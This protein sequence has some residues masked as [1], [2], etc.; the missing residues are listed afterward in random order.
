MI[1]INALENHA[2]EPLSGRLTSAIT[3]LTPADHRTLLKKQ[4][5]LRK[6]T[7]KIPDDILE[8]GITIPAN[9]TLVFAQEEA[10]TAVCVSPSGVILTCSHCVAETE[11]DLSWDKVHW[12]LFASGEAVAA[13]TV[14][15]DP[16]RDLALMV[17]VSASNPSAS[18]PHVNLAAKAPRS[19]TRFLCV[20]HPASE[21]LETSIPGIQTNYDTLVLSEGN[22]RGLAR[23]QDPHDNQEIGALMHD[24]WTYWGHSGAPLIDRNTGNLVGLH[25]SWDENTGMRRGIPWEALVEFMDKTSQAVPRTCIDLTEA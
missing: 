16:Q 23:G 7:I 24:C 5:W 4:S 12:L 14:A 21:D 20:G 9:A 13:K 25:S 10:G 2:V 22:F 19:R 6:Y 1:L 17:V 3:R 15:W 11:Q 18:F 8:K